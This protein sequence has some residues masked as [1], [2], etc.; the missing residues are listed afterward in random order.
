MVTVVRGGESTSQEAGGRGRVGT[1]TLTGH[2]EKNHFKTKESNH[3]DT[4]LFWKPWIRCC[5]NNMSWG[6]KARISDMF[7]GVTYWNA[8]PF[9]GYGV[10]GTR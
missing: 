6:L 3:F 9:T 5:P 4:H 1:P 10:A 7:A 8:V 2:F